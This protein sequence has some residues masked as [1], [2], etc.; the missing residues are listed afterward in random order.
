MV[1]VGPGHVLL[2]DDEPALLEALEEVLV[3]AGFSVET[4]PDGEQALER[5]EGREP[6]VV[7]ADVE[8]PGIGGFELCRRLR[9]SGRRHI[10]F[11]FCSGRSAPD[12]LLEGLRAGAD[13]YLHKPAQ[14]AELVLRLKRQV[15]RIRALRASGRAEPALDASLLAAIEKRLLEGSAQSATVGRF[16]LQGVL[17]RGSM[18]TVFKGWDTKLERFVAVKTVRANASA[19]S[20]CN[21]ELVRRLVSEAAMIARFNHPHVVIVHDVH[22]ARDTAYIVMEYID[23]I[24]LQ[25][26]L[27]DG[28]R[29]GPRDAVPLLAAL[30]RA[31]AAAHAVHLVHRDLKPGNVLIGRDASIK[32]TD[33]GIASFITS[34]VRGTVFGT[35]G[36]LAPEVLR[37]EP[38]QPSVDLFAL[39]ALAYRTLAGRPAFAGKTVQEI[40]TNTLNR[41]PDP[42]HHAAPDVPGEL[43]AIVAALLQ[44]DPTRRLADAARLADD[45]ARLAASNGWEWTVPP[46]DSVRQTNANGRAP[47]GIYHAQLLATHPAGTL[48]L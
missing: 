15:E 27:S 38:I 30:A 32:L 47:S 9:S 4:A 29:L 14:P 2:V 13:D 48:P 37:G 23:G 7:V 28:R 43:E 3:S 12:S 25:D 39:G 1:D 35:P 19:A 24:S 8:M 44:P 26:L 45:L 10:P 46:I 20:F 36:F 40:L 41:R 31:L 22:D 42:L 21:G 11:L 5:I 34:P 33:F 18:G 16:E 17:G 6:D